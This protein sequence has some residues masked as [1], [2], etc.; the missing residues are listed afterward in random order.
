MASEK[1]AALRRGANEQQLL[2]EFF[3]L[4]VATPIL[5]AVF[6]PPSAMPPMLLA[7]AAVGLVLLHRTPTFHWRELLQ[8]WRRIDWRIVA[9]FAALTAAASLAL[10]ALLRPEAYLMLLRVNPLLWLA[11]ML[12]Y[13]ILSALPQEIVFR[14]LFFRRYQRILPSGRTALVLN[15]AIFSL[16][17]LMYWNWVAA[18]A[19]FL[20]GLVFAWAYK[21]RSSFPLA[22]ALHAVAGN[23]LFTSGIGIFF[24]TGAI[25]PPF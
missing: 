7:V 20:G 10:V 16:A 24:Y 18:T 1:T 5:M 8:G 23:I 19:T 2:A 14:P 13:P 4:F 3:S 15:A 9:A 21:A 25:D 22:F 12:L 11:V 17:H 6:A